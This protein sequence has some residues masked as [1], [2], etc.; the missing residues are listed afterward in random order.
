MEEDGIKVNNKGL[1]VD[2]DF[3]QTLADGSIQDKKFLMTILLTSRVIK[4]L[5]SETIPY[6]LSSIT[7]PFTGETKTLCLNTL[8]KVM[9]NM[10]LRPLRIPEFKITDLFM[11]SSAGPHGPSTLTCLKSMFYY[12]LINITGLYSLTC[13][14]GCKFI[15]YMLSNLGNLDF[16]T[17][18]GVKDNVLTRRLSIVKDPECK[19]RVIAIFDWVTQMFLNVLANQ[20][21]DIL[22]KI[23]AD[24]TFTQD[25]HF[26]HIQY[27]T[28]NNFHSLDL[29]AATDRLPIDLQIQVLTLLYG[30]TVAEG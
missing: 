6:S 28:K 27:S 11:I 7:D 26:S 25:P 3:Y 9:I 1:P 8:R 2:F 21:Y 16:T 14:K 15:S 5:K 30:R 29:T 17:Q 23:R 24:R 10:G 13:Q 20:I 4:P 18:K 19:M 22:R 12:N